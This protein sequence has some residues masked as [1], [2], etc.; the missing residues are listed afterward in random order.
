MVKFEPLVQ[1][2]VED[3]EVVVEAAVRRWQNCR[4][5]HGPAP[6][7]TRST[8]Q[9][10]PPLLWSQRLLRLRPARPAGE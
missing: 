2:D 7:A 5:K 9:G 6:D 4:R 8:P 1:C 3:C 10:Q